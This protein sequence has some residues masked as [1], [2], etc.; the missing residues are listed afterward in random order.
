GEIWVDDLVGLCNALPLGALGS[1]GPVDVAEACPI[2]AAWDRTDNLDSPGA[3]LFR[4]I[5]TRLLGQTLPSG[6]TTQTRIFPTSGFLLPYSP[7]DPVNT[8]SGLNAAN[9]I[10][11]QALAD[12]VAELRALGIPL[13]AKLRDHQF[14]ERAGERIPL[15]GGVDRHG[16]FS[17]I[18]VDWDPTTG[19]Y[20]NPHHGNTYTQ[21]VSFDGGPCPRLSTNTTYGQSQ[22]P[23][24]PWH[25]DQTHMYS[26]KQWI[27]VP[28]CEK[29]VAAKTRSTLELS[30]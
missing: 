2:L 7:S 14:V 1:S 24:S 10:V 12:A 29:D 28:F 9:P 3:L 5:A 23:T 8:P 22:D 27:D 17:I 26:N 15:H 21:V 11:Q 16:L 18:N 20:A 19:N 6:T 25:S 4:R 13:D 30:E